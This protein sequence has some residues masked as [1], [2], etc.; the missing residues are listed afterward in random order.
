MTIP[1]LDRPIEAHRTPARHPDEPN[2][3]RT[4][5]LNGKGEP[6]DNADRRL[7]SNGS[8]SDRHD[9][10]PGVSGRPKVDTSLPDTRRPHPIAGGAQRRARIT[11]ASL[12]GMRT[13]NSADGTAR[14]GFDW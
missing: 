14:K 8:S 6:L 2:P 13:V 3:T 9:A 11:R 7:A 12:A 1:S 10:R 5:P 4:E